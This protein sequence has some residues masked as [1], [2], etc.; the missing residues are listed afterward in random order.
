VKITVLGTG[1]SQGIP[2]IGCN[3]QVC[4]SPFAQDKRYRASIFIEHLGKKILIDTSPDLRNQFLKNSI[5]DID[6][7]LYTHE[8]N[9]HIVGLDDIRPI[10]FFQQKDI[11]IYAEQRVMDALALKYDYIF[12]KTYPGAPSI[13]PH[14][15]QPEVGFRIEDTDVVPLRVMH[16]SLPILGFRIDNFAYLTDTSFVD[17][18]TMALMEN[19]DCLIVSAL[20]IEKHPTHFNLEDAL[21]FAKAINAKKTYFTHMSHRMGRHFDIESKLPKSIYLAYDNLTFDI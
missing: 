16:G 9:D 4:A 15:V 18:E 12:N 20:H 6:A 13:V 10:N 19:L 7:I 14:L 3:C 5:N 1:T 2:L 8:H 17:P 11:P 21:A